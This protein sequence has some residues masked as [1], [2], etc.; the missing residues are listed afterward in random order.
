MK[1]LTTR[2]E[3]TWRKRN[4]E[5]KYKV[6]VVGHEYRWQEF[7]EDLFDLGASYCTG[8]NVDILSLKRRVPTFA[9]DCTDAY[10][11]APELDDVVVEPPEEYLNRLRAAGMSTHIWWRLPFCSSS[12]SST[13]PGRPQGFSPWTRLFVGVG[14]ER[15]HSSSSRSGRWE[16][17]SRC[18]PR[19]E[20]N[21][22]LWSRTRFIPVPQGRGVG[23]GLLGLRPD[24]NSAASS[25]RPRGAADEVF[26]SVFSHLSPGEKKCDVGSALGV[27]NECGLYFM[28]A[29]GLWRPHG[30]R[31]SAGG[32]V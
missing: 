5:W 8:R 3:K 13:P 31:A 1:H 22:V 32:G 26:Y 29:S 12:R 18:T 30:A 10:H 19:T 4:N 28:D 7:R 20:F 15:G 24:P 23:R 16:R 27:G 9:L 17:S 21:S 11:Q 6:R 14:A 25:A 2:W